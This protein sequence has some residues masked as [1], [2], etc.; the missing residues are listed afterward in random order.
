M[1][2][3]WHVGTGSDQEPSTVDLDRFW[4]TSGGGVYFKEALQI[5]KGLI[6]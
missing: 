6:S 2:G 1:T 3:K 4:G 5:R